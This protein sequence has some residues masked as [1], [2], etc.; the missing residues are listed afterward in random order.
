MWGVTKDAPAVPYACDDPRANSYAR[1][2]LPCWASAG[3]KLSDVKSD[4]HLPPRS[5]EQARLLAQHPAQPGAPC[6]QEHAAAFAGLAAGGSWA[7]HRSA[8][9]GNA[10]SQGNA[11]GELARG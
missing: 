9:R 1:A 2:A 4:N 5:S 10:F 11:L 6:P 3:W 7:P 8:T